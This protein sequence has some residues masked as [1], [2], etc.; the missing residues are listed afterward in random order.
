MDL[1]VSLCALVPDGGT[2]EENCPHFMRANLPTM[3]QRSATISKS[4]NGAPKLRTRHDFFYKVQGQLHI[5]QRTSLCDLV[6]YAKV[7]MNI[8]RIRR[9]D[10]FL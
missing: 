7:S 2:V 9:D 3:L 5:M 10:Q 8:Q 6:V 1:C 4:P